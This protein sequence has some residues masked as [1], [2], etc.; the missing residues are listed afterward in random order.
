MLGIADEEEQRAD[1]DLRLDVDLK[2][3][4]PGRA[5]LPG[6]PTCQSPAL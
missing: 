4:D 2:V 1:V 6:R 5:D 3:P